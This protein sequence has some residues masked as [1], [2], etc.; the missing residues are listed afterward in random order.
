M[1][2][3]SKIMLIYALLMLSCITAYG[4]SA[5][6]SAPGAQ[7]MTLCPV[8]KVGVS[9]T[10]VAVTSSSQSYSLQ[11]N[12]SCVRVFNNSG[13]GWAFTYVFPFGGGGGGFNFQPECPA[14]HPYMQSMKEVWAGAFTY[15]AY[16]FVAGGA[17]MSITCCTI[18]NPTMSIMQGYDAPTSTDPDTLPYRNLP[19]IDPTNP[20]V[21]NNS[22]GTW[23][24]GPDCL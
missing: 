18:D 4:D 13:G 2:R 12:T 17:G 11:P 7:N 8:V 22:T 20:K 10:P 14:D 24:P 9:G 3:K 21:P 16:G 1:K 5:G 19:A 15:M 6:L 23:Q